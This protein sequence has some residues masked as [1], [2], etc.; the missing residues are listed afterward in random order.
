VVAEPAG[1]SR[2][3]ARTSPTSAT[4]TATGPLRGR[5][6]NIKWYLKREGILDISEMC[7]LDYYLVRWVDNWKI[8]IRP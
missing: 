2:P 4:N 1:S 6:V 7:L 5:S 3:P 8:A